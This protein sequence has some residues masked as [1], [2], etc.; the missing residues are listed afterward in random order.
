[1]KRCIIYISIVLMSLS[2]WAQT[3]D[4]DQREVYND[5]ENAY[6]IGRVE[7]VQ[8]LLGDRVAFFKGTLKQSAYRLLA[9]ANLE[10]DKQEEAEQYVRSLLRENPYYS[11]VPDDP[12]RFVDMVEDIKS[13][14]GATITTASSKAE[15]LNESPVPVTL[16]T[17]EMIRN[18]GGRNLKEVLMAYVPGMLS[19]D[20]NDD[21]NMAMRSIY[22]AGQEKIL[23]ML[24]GHRLNSY[25]TNVAAPDFSL[26]LEKVKQIEVLR[27]PASSL[28]GGVAL[29]AVVNI[30]TKQGADMDGFKVKGSLG[31]Y[32]QVRGDLL[33]GKRYFDLD[34]LTWG[35]IYKAKGERFFVPSMFSGTGGSGDIIVG[36][37]G[38]K[39]SYDFGLTLNWNGFSFMYDTHF[40]QIISPYTFSYTFSP[41][42]YDLYHTFRGMSPGYGTK[43]SHADLSYTK[44]WGDLTLKA[45]V[46]YDSSDMMRYNIVTE[47]PTEDALSEVLG[48]SEYLDSLLTDIPGIYR[49]LDGQDRNYGVQLKGDY[50]YQ[51]NK[52]HQGVL[53]FGMHYNKF[54]MID[55]KFIL[56]GYYD[57]TL[58]DVTDV[59]TF[60]KGKE[61][62]LDA[63]VQ[64]KHTWNNFIFNAG[65]RFDSKKRF[66]DHV[67]R[68]LSPR[69]A[70][71]YMQPKWNA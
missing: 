34:V 65:L 47:L 40:S 27:G 19:V 6:I 39:P 54:E 18:S 5:A 41:Y 35:S 21:I 38:N 56:G 69:I 26:S 32:G 12:Q 58:L 68:E 52:S 25:S 60:A 44:N 59:S 23:F 16:I 24:N 57:I 14:M 28:Y 2:T 48:T 17:E 8:E 63:F 13:G 42:S 29:S 9:L 33:F 51:L 7:Q 11:T 67:V 36:G 10:L 37:V 20:C 43:S 71:I 49:Y 66:D 53:S 62:S 3:Q 61:H 50:S 4:D 31:N 46:T 15:N 45:S 30:I 55:S 70:L 1:M 22:S 64:L